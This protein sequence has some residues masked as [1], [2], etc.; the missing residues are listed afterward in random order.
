[1]TTTATP[2]PDA[3]PSASRHVI[4]RLMRPVIDDAML[5]EFA[6]VAPID[7]VVHKIRARCDGLIDRVLVGFPAS[8]DESTVVGLVS[9][10]QVEETS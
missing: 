7:D 6:V 10:L 3:V 9:E 5:A 4:V 1:M 8:L 2:R